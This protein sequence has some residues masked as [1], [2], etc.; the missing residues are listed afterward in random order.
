MLSQNLRYAFRF[1]A[2]TAIFS[3]V[4]SALLRP[5]PYRNSSELLFIGESRE[6]YPQI[7]LAQSS[8]SDFRDWQR[9]SKT[10]QSLAGY[11]G[12]HS[13]LDTGGEPKLESATTVTT[14]F[15]STLGVKLPLGRDF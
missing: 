7:D 3:V 2:N 13:I 15:F 6:Q 10:F 12:D 11:G 8:Y 9:S 14:N 4:Y 1:G 5:L